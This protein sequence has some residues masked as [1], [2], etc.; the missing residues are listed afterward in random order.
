MGTSEGP[1]WLSVRS[2]FFLNFKVCEV[3]GFVKTR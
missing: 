1:W 2:G 3:G